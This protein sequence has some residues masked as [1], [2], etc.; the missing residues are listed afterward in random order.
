MKKH[1]VTSVLFAAFAAGSAVAADMPAKA[2]PAPCACTCDAAQFGGGYIGVSGGGVKHVANRTD[3]D[4]FLVD[5]STYVTEKWGGIVGGTLGYNWARCHTLWGIEIDG[6][7]ASVNNTL[8]L[9]PNSAFNQSLTNRLD[10]FLTARVRSGVAWDNVLL[11]LT[12]G[13]AAARFRTTWQ[14][15]NNG[16]TPFDSVEFNEWRWGWVAGFGSEWAWTPNLTIK[17]EV[18]YANFTDRDHSFRFAS[19]GPATFKH[20]DSVWISRIGINY[21]W[22][23]PVRAAY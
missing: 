1:I 11:Y 22:G 20:S 13:V 12:G 5:A 21:K 4:E 9:H 15:F 18:L 19:F 16:L 3:R 7:W 17:S 23:A 8:T 6:S 2:P 14:D 10:A